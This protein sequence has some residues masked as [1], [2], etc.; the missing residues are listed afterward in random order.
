MSRSVTPAGR[1]ST[2]RRP[3]AAAGRSL[4]AALALLPA[5]AF[6]VAGAGVVAAQDGEFG[7]AAV[8]TYFSSDLTIVIN[9]LSR[10]TPYPSTTTVSGL[11]GVTEDVNL[12]LENFN[13][14]NPDDVD[15]LLVNPQ[16]DAVTV[17]SD[18]GGGENVINIDL[19]IDDNVGST[20]TM[21]DSARLASGNYYPSN[22]DGGDPFPNPA[23]SPSGPLMAEFND[24][25][26]NGAW[27]LFVVDDAVDG[28]GS[29]TGRWSLTI[30]TS[31]TGPRAV[32]DAYTATAGE[33]LKVRAPGVL[34]NDADPDGDRLTARRVRTTRQGKLQLDANGSFTYTPGDNARGTDSF[35]YEA[36]DT[37]GNVDRAIV[38]IAIKRR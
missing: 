38:T 35:V 26:P 19:T 1:P 34:R 33:T 29:F 15:I 25:N 9:D 36:R 24:K 37:N 30:T 32:D 14:T 28:S 3:R 31:N 21:P 23:P 2:A 11:T 16:G 6:G 13:H 12:H 7:P 22:Y 20:N 10:A 17:M 8:R 18:V 5:V 4:V 27:Q